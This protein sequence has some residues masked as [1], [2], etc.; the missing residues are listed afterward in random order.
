MS[1][2]KLMQN[3][4]QHNRRSLEHHGHSVGGKTSLT[5]MSW[6]AMKQR[7]LCPKNKDYKY[8]G[9][10]GVKVDSLWVSSF[11]TFLNDM[12]ERPSKQHSLDRIDPDG[13]YSKDNCRWVLKS[14]NS[15][16][17]NRKL[18]KQIV[19]DIRKSNETHSELAIK[20]GVCRQ[21]IDNIIAYRTWRERRVYL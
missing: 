21:T 10:K 6:R 20:Y 5:Y 2:L 16:R 7:C 9:G 1:V 11:V 13:D 17:S 4:N 19:E 12:G 3:K 15:H 8:Y 18:T 14:T